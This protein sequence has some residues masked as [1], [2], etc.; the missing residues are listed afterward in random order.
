MF[1][2]L[3]NDCSKR[4]RRPEWG[5]F[6]VLNCDFYDPKSTVRYAFPLAYDE[7]VRLPIDKAFDIV[8]LF[9][10][11]IRKKMEVIDPD[12]PRGIDFTAPYDY[13]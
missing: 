6:P 2:D 10:R 4:H 3:S 8:V 9:N 5:A 11:E 12:V 7:L 1:A 13:M